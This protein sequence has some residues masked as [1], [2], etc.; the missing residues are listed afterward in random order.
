MCVVFYRNER[1]L[2]HVG[3][4]DTTKN[5]RWGDFLIFILRFLQNCDP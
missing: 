3:N 4:Q 5:S 2:G 1:L